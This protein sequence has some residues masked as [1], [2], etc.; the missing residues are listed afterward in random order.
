MKYDIAITACVMDLF[1]TGHLD[2][3]NLMEK[4]ADRTV[5]FL[6][7]SYSTFL[8]KG[9]FPVHNTAQREYNILCINKN[10]V[11]KKV[12]DKNPGEEFKQFLKNN[13]DKRI[14]YIR[15][16]DWQDFPGRDVI[17]KYNVTII[18]KKY[19][20]GISSTKIKENL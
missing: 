7:N 6:H 8:N 10:I 13:K 17:E 1:H 3:L 15:G 9:H 11:I 20:E 19:S 18:F 5:L 14:C 12:Y 2:L 16:D 4:N